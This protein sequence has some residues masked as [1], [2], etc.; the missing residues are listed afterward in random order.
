M[1]SSQQIQID[2]AS[3]IYARVDEVAKEQRLSHSL[4]FPIPT[5]YPLRAYKL[6]FMAARSARGWQLYRLSLRGQRPENL[7]RKNRRL[8]NYA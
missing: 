3:R 2:A 8:P 4:V 1:P 5:F 7:G 6:V